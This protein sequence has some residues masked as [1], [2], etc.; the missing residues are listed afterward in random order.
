MP[1]L[2]EK[3]VSCQRVRTEDAAKEIGCHRQYMLNKMASGQW[4]LGKVVHKK[5][6]GG[7]NEYFIFR[8]KLDKFLAKESGE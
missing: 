3:D 6:A 7:K 5:K 2:K 4:D 8:A 1:K